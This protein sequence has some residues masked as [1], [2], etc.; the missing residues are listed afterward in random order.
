[1]MSGQENE[2]LG[3]CL[4]AFLLDICVMKLF[5]SPP[6]DL[7]RNPSI[8]T[9]RRV[10]LGEATTKYCSILYLGNQTTKYYSIQATTKFCSIHYVGNHQVL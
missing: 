10:G 1:M 2:Y 8:S 5:L 7:A 9:A 4:S 3:I 6:R